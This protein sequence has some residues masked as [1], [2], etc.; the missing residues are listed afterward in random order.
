MNNKELQ[1]Y[2]K[3]YPDDLDILLIP[4]LKNWSQTIPFTEE[5]ILHTSYTAYVDDEADEDDWDC[6]DGRIELGDGKR[7]LLFNPVIV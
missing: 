2:L 5:N 4:D 1:E 3:Q 6:E 7:Y